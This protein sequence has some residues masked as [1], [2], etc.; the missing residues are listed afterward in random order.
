MGGVSFVP[1]SAEEEDVD[2]TLKEE[3]KNRMMDDDGDEISAI[4]TVAE[5]TKYIPYKHSLQAFI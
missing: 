3:I 2:E 1:S 5:R 4:A